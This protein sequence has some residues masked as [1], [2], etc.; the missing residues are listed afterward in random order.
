L[1]W[2][3]T[4]PEAACVAYNMSREI[5]EASGES[6]IRVVEFLEQEWGYRPSGVMSARAKMA[7]EEVDS[8][9]VALLNIQVH[10]GPLR[11]RIFAKA[12]MRLQAPAST[13]FS[14]M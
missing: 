12:S 7:K 1:I 11:I 8:V 10:Y 9:D 5:D 14:F 13:S 2:H 3:T 4:L 6:T